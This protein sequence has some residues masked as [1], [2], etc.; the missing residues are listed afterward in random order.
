MLTGGQCAS[1][2]SS[3]NVALTTLDCGLCHRAHNA[4]LGAEDERDF[5][6]ILRASRRTDELCNTCH[7]ADNPTCGTVTDQMAS[8]FLGDPG[9]PDTYDDPNTPV[10]TDPWPESALASVY[11]GPAGKTILCL[12]CHSFR[13][14]ALISGDDGGSG[15]LLARAGNPMEWAEGEEALYLCTGCHGVTPGTGSGAKGPTHPLMSAD[16]AEL[17]LPVTPPG[18]ATAGGRINCDSCHRPHEAVTAAGVYIMEAARGANADPE[19]IQPKIDFTP[20]CH[21]CHE[22]SKY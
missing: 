12:S 4:G 6:P 8:H 17:G 9:L 13:P 21:L 15:N 10:R 5:V 18:S 2:L 20:T 22:A 3:A 7:T 11:G 16:V 1:K 14:G 19:A